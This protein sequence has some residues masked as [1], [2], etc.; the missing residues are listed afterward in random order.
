MSIRLAWTAK[1]PQ[2]SFDNW[3]GPMYQLMHAGIEVLMEVDYNSAL[4]VDYSQGI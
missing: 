3:L 4:I 2:N 1:F